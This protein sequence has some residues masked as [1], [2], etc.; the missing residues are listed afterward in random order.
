MFWLYF[1]HAESNNVLFRKRGL[2][3]GWYRGWTGLQFREAKQGQARPSRKPC[4]GY[5]AMHINMFWDPSLPYTLPLRKSHLSPLWPLWP[6]MG[7]PLW[8]RWPPYPCLIEPKINTWNNKIIHCRLVTFQI[9][10]FCWVVESI[11]QKLQSICGG[12]LS[13]KVL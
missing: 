6:T 11:G 5:R 1:S 9:F 3:L 8:P 4:Q 10:F 13:R 7:H 2:D 12:Y